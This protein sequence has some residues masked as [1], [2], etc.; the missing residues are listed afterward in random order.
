MWEIADDLVLRIG[1]KNQM[2][3]EDRNIEVYMAGIPT[4]SLDKY[5]NV[6]VENFGWSVVVVDQDTFI[7]PITTEQ[8]ITRYEAAVISPGTNIYSMNETNILMIIY[9]ERVASSINKGTSKLYAGLSFIDCLTGYNGLIEYPTT[10]TATST[11]YN[12]SSLDAIIL[13]EIMNHITIKNP[14][15]LLIYTRNL[16]LTETDIIN[17]FHLNYRN[18]RIIQDDNEI[19]KEF[20]KQQKQIAL[21]HQIFGSKLSINHIFDDL[22]IWNFQYSRIVLVIMLE[23][24]IKRNPNLLEKLQKPDVI[25]ASNSHLILA[26]NALE[27]LNIVSNVSNITV[28]RMMRGRTSLLDILMKTKTTMGHRLF[29]SRLL[30]PITTPDILEK[31]Y[32]A[33]E[34]LI[35]LETNAYRTTGSS[36]ISEINKIL[37][38]MLDFKRVERQLAQN[39]LPLFNVSS[40]IETLKRVKRLNEFLIQTLTPSTHSSSNL[41]FILSETTQKE[42]KNFIKKIEKTFIL[43]TCIDAIGKLEVN[44]FQPNTFQELDELQDAINQDTQ[45]IDAIQ[46]EL[47][48]II[49]GETSSNRSNGTKET[50]I[51]GQ[52]S[53]YKQYIYTTVP[54]VEIIKKYLKKKSDPL[55]IKWKHNS[56]EILYLR[57]EDFKFEMISKGKIRIDLE[58]IRTAGYNLTENYIRLRHTIHSKYNEWQDEIYGKYANL[59]NELEVYIANLDVIQSISKTS[60]KNGYT[61]PRIENSDVSSSQSFIKVKGLRHPIIES[62]QTDIPYVPNDITMGMDNINGILLF[63]V[64]AVGKSSLMKSIGIAVIMAQA[65]FFVPCKSLEYKPFNYLFTRIQNNDNIFAGLSSF[66]VEMSELKIIMNYADKNSIILGDELCSGTETLDAT[67]LVA[68]GIQKLA[69]RNVNFI[70]ATHL[71]SLSTSRYITE[72]Q[73]VRKVHLS[74]IYDNVSKK[75]IYE[76]CIRDGSGPSSY[77]IEVCKAMNMSADYMELAQTIRAE[78]T[79]TNAADISNTI[80]AGKTSVYNVNKILTKCEVCGS[81]VASDTHHIKFQ[82]SAD[83]NNM[84]EHWHKDIKFNL[85]GLCKECHQSVHSAP[86]RLKIEGYCTT[87]NNTELQFEW[88]DVTPDFKATNG[89]FNDIDVVNDINDINLL[90]QEKGTKTEKEKERNKGNEK[91]TR[92]ITLDALIIE[93]IIKFNKRNLTHKKIQYLIKSSH[94]ISIKI[95]DIKNIIG[96]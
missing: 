14:A 28:G 21:L 74:V 4:P 79:M 5:I 90:K 83:S 77:G 75:L 62:I 7:D 92:T 80:V 19:L 68:A 1:K 73:N 57:A 71:H 17:T 25:I 40:L 63:G 61:R 34:T 96:L 91:E 10:T 82:C 13:D 20:E 38:G 85:V 54:R 30:N 8:K 42:L 72:L 70:F 23:Y 16:G 89:N 94:N 43:E 39:I 53:E 37:S 11:D 78:L 24:I 44:V 55:K 12:A 36:I 26:N 58:C 47:A 2:A 9:I 48:S 65:G 84:I 60:I 76:R 31:R 18:H 22:G 29:K 41:T 64:N 56:N 81:S 69:Q 93:D 15:E 88:L 66:A 6:A 49:E 87:S 32:D 86:P 50:V 67:A 27:Q 33:I 52:N 46:N 3:Y 59:M 95:M 35:E 45:L 51:Q